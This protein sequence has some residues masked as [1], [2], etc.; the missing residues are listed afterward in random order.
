MIVLP[1]PP[2]LWVP[3]PASNGADCVVIRSLGALLPFGSNDP[4]LLLSLIHRSK[5]IFTAPYIY[6]TY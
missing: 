6:I 4:V 1:S 3:A 2:L 5:K